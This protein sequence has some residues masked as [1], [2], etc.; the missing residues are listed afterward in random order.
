MNEKRL[1]IDF[2]SAVSQFEKTIKKFQIRK[3]IYKSVFRGKGLDFD[4]YRDFEPDDDADFIDWKATLRAGKML[5]KKYIEERDVNIYFVVDV[6]SGMLFGSG[7][8]LKAEYNAE[9]VAALSHLI[10]SSGDNAG[11]VLFSDKPVYYLH[12]SKSKN[13]F[14]LIIKGLGDI[15]NYGGKAN[16][17]AVIEFLLAKIK[18]PLSIIVFLSDFISVDKV[19]QEFFELIST[20]FETISM[21]VLDLFDEN[22]PKTTS[23]MVIQDPY[24]GRQMLVDPKVAA[25]RYSEAAIFHKN[26]VRQIFKESRVDLLELSTATSFTIPIVSFLK[27]RA[28]GVNRA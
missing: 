10:I 18:D 14:Q 25:Q 3:I 27:A 12:P 5:T 15:K 13:Q 1:E 4:G 2:S 28:K 9:I 16:F 8:K 26:L 11:L 21:M 17:D 19:N 20:R 7:D 23:Q 24:S 22:I 6:S